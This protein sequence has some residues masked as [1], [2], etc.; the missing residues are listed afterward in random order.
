MNIFALINPVKHFTWSC[1][2]KVNKLYKYESS[3][4]WC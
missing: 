3:N 4:C 2:E 1:T